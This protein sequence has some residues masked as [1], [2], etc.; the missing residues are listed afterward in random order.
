MVCHA[1][2]HRARS[3]HRRGRSASTG[4]SPGLARAVT[5]TPD[6]LRIGALAPGSVI[7]VLGAC[8]GAGAS[9]FAAALAACP[10]SP[11]AQSTLLDLDP[12]GGGLDVLLG[13]DER[14][15]ARWSDIRLSGGVLD[16]FALRERLPSC[17]GVAVLACDLGTDPSERDVEQVLS[18]ARQSGPVVLDLPRWLP[19]PSRAALRQADAAVVLV[20]GDVRAVVAG[21]GLL[22]VL[23]GLQ[24][25]T[26]AVIRPGIVP[27]PQAAR[28]LGAW[29]GDVLPVVGWFS[30]DRAGCLNLRAIPPQVAGLA[31]RLWSRAGQLP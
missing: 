22:R 13:L 1:G 27:V 8:G 24:V 26:I 14:A 2:I 30:G 7:A 25:Q 18:A 19:A 31:A 16:P 9:S 3:F 28:M 6:S 11:G 15:G 12:A 10:P 4:P 23:E 20:P 21:A 17:A 29:G 5:S